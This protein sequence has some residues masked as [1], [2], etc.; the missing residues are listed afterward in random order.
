[1]CCVTVPLWTT[2]RARGASGIRKTRSPAS[3]TA[4]SSRSGLPL[5]EL[6]DSYGCS[7][8]MRQGQDEGQ[9]QHR[10]HCLTAS[11]SGRPRH[12]CHQSLANPWHLPH[13][14]QR[15]QSVC[16][17]PNLC[18]PPCQCTQVEAIPRCRRL[19]DKMSASERHWLSRLVARRGGVRLPPLPPEPH[20]FE[21]MSLE[22]R[23][24]AHTP[25]L[26]TCEFHLVLVWP[27]TSGLI[28]VPTN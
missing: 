21:H 13:N 7:Y 18:K 14:L 19:L 20:D 16:A 6:C 23:W 10:Q 5:S 3:G 26:F 1:M 27:C 2:G 9:C 8:Q 12:T 22:E 15:L 25:M 24:A 28:I 4:R 11:V 17:V